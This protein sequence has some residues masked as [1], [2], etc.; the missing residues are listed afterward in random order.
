[1]FG[2]SGTLEACL[3]FQVEGEADVAREH[4]ERGTWR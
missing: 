3:S 4:E 2:S 1:M